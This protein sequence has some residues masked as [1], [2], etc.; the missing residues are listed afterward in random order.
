MDRMAEKIEFIA[1]HNGMEKVLDKL[2]EECAEYT[3]ARLQHHE[4]GTEDWIG[5]LADVWILMRQAGILMGRDTNPFL[6]A[7]FWMKAEEKIE[8]QIRRIKRDGGKIPDL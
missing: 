6:P 4:R 3:A 5:E 2:A 7:E 8:R 1:E